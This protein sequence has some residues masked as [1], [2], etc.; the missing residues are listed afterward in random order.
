MTSSPQK[1]CDS[2]AARGR[3]PQS[4][5]PRSKAYSRNATY[6]KRC[7][8]GSTTSAFIREAFRRFAPCSVTPRTWTR[9]VVGDALSRRRR[10]R[11]VDRALSRLNTARRIECPAPDRNAPRQGRQRQIARSAALSVVNDAI[12]PSGWAQASD[13]LAWSVSTSP[14]LAFGTGPAY[15]MV[16]VTSGGSGL[17]SGA[18]QRRPPGAYQEPRRHT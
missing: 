9:L 7:D 12:R 6:Q 15:L 3:G 4:V 5:R 17:M 13:P 1:V 14:A 2:E 8:A 11:T 16:A 18:V 10:D